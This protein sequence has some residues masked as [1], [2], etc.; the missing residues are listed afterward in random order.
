MPKKQH[1]A[2]LIALFSLLHMGQALSTTVSLE[3][4]TS[5][6]FVGGTFTVDVLLADATGGDVAA[7]NK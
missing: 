2:G 4:S 3:S 1:L 7:F 6:V 5:A